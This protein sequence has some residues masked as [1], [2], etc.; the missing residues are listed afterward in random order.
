[1][2]ETPPLQLRP[3]ILTAAS[4]AEFGDVIETEGRPWRWINAGTCQRFDD[5]AEVDVLEAGG[6][7]AISVFQ[8][9]PRR[10]PMSVTLLERHPL[11]S[12]SFY[13]LDARR[14]LALVARAGDAPWSQRLVAFLCSGQQGVS[15]RRNTWHHA[16]IALDQV[17]RFL[18]LDRIGP[19]ENCEE[20]AIGQGVIL[21]A[22]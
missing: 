19:G 21:L 1:M 14:Y 10:L 16:L 3:T 17:S 9:Q 5:L 6:R 4:F 2:S 22:P 18:V 11:S 8:A 15:Y 13:P 12:Q 20:L 7:G